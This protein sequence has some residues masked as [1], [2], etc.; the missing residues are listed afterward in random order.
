M[1]LA[2]I[3]GSVITNDIGRHS[4]SMDHL[5]SP[6]FTLLTLRTELRCWRADVERI[7]EMIKR[8]ASGT[9]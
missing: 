1:H 5:G 6:V 8:G 9:T 2:K 7:Y 3:R 4:S